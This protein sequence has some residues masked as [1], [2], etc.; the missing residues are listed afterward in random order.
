MTNTELIKMAR[1]RSQ[2]LRTCAEEHQDPL[3]ADILDEA[4]DALQAQE[5]QPIVTAN[6]G[7]R[8][9]AGW[10]DG[11]WAEIDIILLTV[12][13]SDWTPETRHAWISISTGNYATP[14]QPHQW[15]THWRPLPTAP[16]VIPSPAQP[17]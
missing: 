3:T 9:E 1:W 8:I 13:R 11:V 2:W 4:I 12:P 15:P 5:W 16:N 17:K 6:P 10:W 14:R 7:E